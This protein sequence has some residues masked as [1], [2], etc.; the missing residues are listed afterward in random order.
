[1]SFVVVAAQF[2][3]DLGVVGAATGA[4][5]IAAGLLSVLLF[6][7]LALLPLRREGSGVATAGR[8]HPPAVAA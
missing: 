1:M 2:G 6:P 7:L 5:A 4:A 8:A 3:M